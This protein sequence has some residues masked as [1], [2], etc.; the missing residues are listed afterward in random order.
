VP[1]IRLGSNGGETPQ[2]CPFA[3]EALNVQNGC[4][5][6]TESL[7]VEWEAQKKAIPFG[8]EMAFNVL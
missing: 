3:P 1:L 2:D 8:N 5:F 7:N 4:M 6:T